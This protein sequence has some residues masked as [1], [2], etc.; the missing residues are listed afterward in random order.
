MKKIKFF[1]TYSSRK[2]LEKR[3]NDS[4]F[5]TSIAASS[6]VLLTKVKKKT[7]IAFNIT[8]FIILKI[9]IVRIFFAS[10]L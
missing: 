5:K 3:D 7:K 6:I 10:F 9:R 8:Y 2:V 4:R 1:N